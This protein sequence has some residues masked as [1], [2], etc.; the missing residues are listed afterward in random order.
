DQIPCADGQDP[1]GSPLGN[2]LTVLVANRRW[3]A[4]GRVER[5]AG[6]HLRP[7]LSQ[8]RRVP[9]ASPRA[10][11][12]PVPSLMG[13]DRTLEEPDL[14]AE[15]GAVIGGRALGGDAGRRMPWPPSRTG[16]P[17]RIGEARGVVPDVTIEVDV[18]AFHSHRVR[19]LEHSRGRVV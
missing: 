19:A 9:A 16:E 3:G 11:K 6:R 14:P 5:L 15:G 13:A 17:R 1:R 12:A 7:E 4:F 8:L 2:G 18:A 10:G